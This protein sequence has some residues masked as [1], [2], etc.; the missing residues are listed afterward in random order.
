[1]HTA[2]EA[3]PC[4]GE[5]EFRREPALW[6]ELVRAWGLTD[7][8]AEAID[9]EQGHACTCCCNNLRSRAL[10]SALLA[11]LGMDGPLTLA[12]EHPPL[13]G[14]RVVEVNEA[15]ALS[16]ILSRIEGHRR[17]EYPDC[18]MRDLPYATGSVDVLLHSDTLE[19]VPDPLVALGE[20]RRVLA[21]DGAMLFTVPTLHRRLTRSRQ[22]LP[23]TYHGLPDVHDEGLRVWTEFGADTWRYVCAAGFRECTA[24]S[25]RSLEALA[26]I[27]RP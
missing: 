1:M 18:D 19:H 22:G 17:L 9:R 25:Y 16:P 20:C 24:Y 3:C 15:G 21:P 12:V 7:E 2:P 6:P 26:W 10:A 23:P 4:C 14:L 8:E 11:H 5:R 27:A 13:A